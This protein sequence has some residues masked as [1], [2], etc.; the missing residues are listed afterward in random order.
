MAPAHA[1][2][3]TAVQLIALHKL[4]LSEENVR[5]TDPGLQAAA[6]LKANIAALGVLSNLV[7]QAIDT[8][9]DLYVVIAGGRRYKALVD[10]AEEGQVPP[11]MPVP[12]RVV[13]ADAS[14][15]EISLAENV[16]RA[17][18]HP[19]DQVEAFAALADAGA[20]V[21]AIAARF[22]VAE[23]TVEQRL[24]LGNVAPELLAAYRDDRIDLECLKAFAVTTD[25]ARQL[26]VWA[27]VSEQGYRPSAWHIKRLLTETRVPG[28][29]AVARFVGADAYE[30]AGGALDRD[31]FADEHD[32]GVWFED[33]RLLDKLAQKHLQ[34]IALPLAQEWKWAEAR[35]EVDWNTTARFGRV[36]AVPAELTP[37]ETAERDRLL[38]RQ[39]ELGNLDEEDWTDELVVEA[40]E[41]EQR[42]AR[43]Q[44]EVDSRAVY[45]DADKAIS[46]CIVTIDHAGEVQ[47]I[48]GLVRP[49]DI[50]AKQ[51]DAD[52]SAGNAHAPAAGNA[53]TVA[54]PR[55]TTPERS[56]DP[57]AQARKEA[58][59]GIGLADDMRAIRTT[60]VKAR[61]STDFAAAFDLFVFQAAR[62][63]FTPG[64]RATALE[65][66]VRETADRPHLRT[67]D[68]SFGDHSPAE[69]ILA[70]R[71][72]LRLDWLTAEDDGEAFALFRALP[73][74][75][76]QDLF[77]ACIARTVKGQLAFEHAARPE[78][79]ATVARLDIDFAAEIRP[80]EEMFWSRIKKSQM[81]D[82]ARATLGKD[83][84]ASHG[85]DKKAVLAQAMHRAFGA[86][87]DLPA[88]V[89]QEG[90]AAALAWTMPGFAAFD[91]ASSA[92]G[93]TAP[94]DPQPA[95]GPAD[96]APAD[97][98]ADD[99]TSAAADTGND[100]TDTANG[101]FVV[102]PGSVPPAEET[103]PSI[104]DAID[105]MNAVPTADGGPRVIVHH[106]G[107]ANGHADMDDALEIPEFLRRT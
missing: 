92:N 59:V 18:M 86:S 7:V 16:L 70:D 13:P 55:L 81:L 76:K 95:N 66:A 25:A 88:G 106:V 1:Q 85:K 61:L 73:L 102:D 97:A 62:S 54:A 42:L 63:V 50:P 65:I 90:R 21:S 72:H 23:R 26:A 40:E 107:A 29:A 24:R 98:G 6:E 35:L 36:H 48:A 105:A 27:Q 47:I 43:M 67:N 58:G 28:N 64:Y 41:I 69:A 60:T 39:D 101:H 96:T 49:D 99:G 3:A 74:D 17:A 9:S 84:A 104:S 83:W 79:E 12:C 51:D 19:V 94:A 78:L 44:E 45:A 56:P 75:A 38:T 15:K 11:H 22:G 93:D 46:G 5:K 103:A 68:D 14:P 4:S 30:A 100:A 71:S 77:A 89:T 34:E 2:P 33:P 32:A 8:T 52:S 91:A 87:D 10:L 82:I 37:D 20:T 53:A 57:A 80:S 31:L